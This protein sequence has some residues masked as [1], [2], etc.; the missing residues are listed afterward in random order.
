MALRPL[1]VVDDRMDLEGLVDNKTFANGAWS[2]IEELK[3]LDDIYEEA[4]AYFL[5]QTRG[6]GR[7]TQTKKTPPRHVRY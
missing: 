1:T 5:R 4:L 2:S 7:P 3:D 6:P